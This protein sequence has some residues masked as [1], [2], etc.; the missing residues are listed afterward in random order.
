MTAADT[1]QLLDEI[2]LFL[3]EMSG[4]V[5]YEERRFKGGL[6]RNAEAQRLLIN[7]K[8]AAPEILEEYYE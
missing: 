6:A 7:L 5:P 2:A 1:L 8:Q 3:K 4:Q